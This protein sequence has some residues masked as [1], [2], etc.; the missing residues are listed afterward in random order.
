[1][2]GTAACTTIK[3]AHFSVFDL[4]GGGGDDA[5]AILSQSDSDFK[6]TGLTASIGIRRP[7]F[8]SRL[9]LICNLRGSV[10]WGGNDLRTNVTVAEVVPVGVGD[11]DLND[12]QQPSLFGSNGN[13]MWIGEVQAGGE[14]NTPISS[15]FGGG[16][17]FIRAMFEGQWWQLPGVTTNSDPTI[18]S[19]EHRHADLQFHRH[20]RRRRFHAVTAPRRPL[21]RIPTGGCVGSLA[22][23][24]A[25]HA[26]HQCGADQQI[27]GHRPQAELAEHRRAEKAADVGYRVDQRD[28]AGRGGAAQKCRGQRPEDGQHAHHA[29]LREAEPGQRHCGDGCQRAEGPAGGG[30]QAAAATWPRR[31]LVRSELMLNSTMPIAAHR[32][33]SALSRPIC[34]RARAPDNASLI[35]VRKIRAAGVAAHGHGEVDRDQQPHPPVQHGAKRSA[36]CVLAL[37]FFL[38]HAVDQPL[39]LFGLPATGLLGAIGEYEEHDDSQ[40]TDGMPSSR[41]SHCQPCS[42]AA[43]SRYCMMKPEIGLPKMLARAM[44]IMKK[45]VIL[46]RWRSGNQSS[47]RE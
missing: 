42:P 36:P 16:N 43:P 7:V 12:F 35:N 32:C 14:W 30:Q 25:A 3:R 4:G 22:A 24:L 47:N 8:E 23:A 33:G 27:D 44:A 40:M 5:T 38:L 34:K 13:G 45:A 11:L 41:N 46:A 2:R 39:P 31:S 1:M 37:G 18:G 20:H 29:D 17:A 9:S 10:L 21:R 19:V 15:D 6:G 28:A 26:H